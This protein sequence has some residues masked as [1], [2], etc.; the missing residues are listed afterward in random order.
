MILQSHDLYDGYHAHRDLSKL[1]FHKHAKTMHYDLQTK[2]L[3][4]FTESGVEKLH[5]LLNSNDFIIQDGG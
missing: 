5:A 4:L 3:T 2:L 1:I